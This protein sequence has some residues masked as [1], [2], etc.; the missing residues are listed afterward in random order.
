MDEF[1]CAWRTGLFVCLQQSGR[2]AGVGSRAKHSA[3]HDDG[4]GTRVGSGS[5]PGNLERK[6]ARAFARAC[7][8]LGHSYII[9]DSRSRD[10]AWLADS[11]SAVW[12]APHWRAGL[13]WL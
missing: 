10:R 1:D 2:T 12:I 4:Y 13:G 6:E 11:G 8:F 5:A 3:A 9:G 7:A